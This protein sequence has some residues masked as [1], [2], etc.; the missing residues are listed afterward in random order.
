LWLLHDQ[1]PWEADLAK[2]GTTVFRSWA[3]SGNQ[4]IHGA[5]SRVESPVFFKLST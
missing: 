4:N 2:I 1:S 5:Q 3:A